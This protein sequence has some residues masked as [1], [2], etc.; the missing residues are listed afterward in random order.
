MTFKAPRVFRHANY[1]L[2]FFGQLVSLMGTWMQAVALGWLVYRLTHSP[3]L[4]GVVS[5]AQQGPIFFLS[6]LGGAIADRRDRRSVFIVT[7]SLAMLFAAG[8]TVL[9]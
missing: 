7:Q 5:F 9:T 1:R 4:L 3:F 2:F 8:L 6:P